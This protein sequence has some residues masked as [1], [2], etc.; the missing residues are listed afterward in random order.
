MTDT[1]DGGILPKSPSLPP[2]LERGARLY[3]LRL[4]SALAGGS[5]V[6]PRLAGGSGTTGRADVGV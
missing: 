5:A 4:V 2:E 6:G 3:G 1:R